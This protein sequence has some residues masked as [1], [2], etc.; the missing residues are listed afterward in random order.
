MEISGDEVVFNHG[1]VKVTMD[2]DLTTDIIGNKTETIKKA[3]TITVTKDVLIKGK[4]VTVEAA[5]TATVKG[6]DCLVDA[7]GSATV[8]AAGVVTISGASI[9]LN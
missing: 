1:E 9:S 6:R 2:K 3:L 8:K 4:N 7:S 5:E